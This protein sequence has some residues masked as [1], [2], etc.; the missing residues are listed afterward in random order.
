M[1]RYRMLRKAEHDFL[2]KEA[3]LAQKVRGDTHHHHPP[4]HPPP[5]QGKERVKLRTLV[6]PE[7]YTATPHA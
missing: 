3:I 5:P 2:G 1:L 4:T 6:L 7:G